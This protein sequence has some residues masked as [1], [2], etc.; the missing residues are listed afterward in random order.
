MGAVGDHATNFVAW[1]LYA[2]NLILHLQLLLIAIPSHASSPSTPL[3]RFPVVLVVEATSRSSIQI[4]GRALDA[5]PPSILSVCARAIGGLRSSID[6]VCI[7]AGEDEPS[8]VRLRVGRGLAIGLCPCV[9][10]RG[11]PSN[12]DGS[13][14]LGYAVSAFYPFGLP[15]LSLSGL[16]WE[17]HGE[18][19]CRTYS[20]PPEPALDQL[21]KR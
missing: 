6:H 18:E 17:M 9:H 4:F 1:R 11:V 7:V 3:L 14:V 20:Q 2:G 21:L 16:S 13:G 10:V 19:Y 5:Y 15:G 12:P 8:I